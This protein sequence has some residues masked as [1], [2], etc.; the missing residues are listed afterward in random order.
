MHS[1]KTNGG[2]SHR[3][4]DKRCYSGFLML[5]EFPS[6]SSCRHAPQ[7]SQHT[8]FVS[9]SQ[10]N[11]VRYHHVLLAMEICR[12]CECTLQLELGVPSHLFIHSDNLYSTS[13]RELLSVPACTSYVMNHPTGT[14]FHLHLHV[15]QHSKYFKLSCKA[16][17]YV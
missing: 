3:T 13:S 5:T 17:D 11:W 9:L 7:L 10:V 15:T 4:E 8:Y 6:R 2:N 12:C 1:I 16:I 14:V